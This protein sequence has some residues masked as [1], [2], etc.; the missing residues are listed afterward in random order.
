MGCRATTH[1]PKQLPVFD[2][3]MHFKG[4]TSG[5]AGPNVSCRCFASFFSMPLHRPSQS[6]CPW[7]VVGT[8]ILLPNA[9]TC[10]TPTTSA[11]GTAFNWIWRRQ[12]RVMFVHNA[13]RLCSSRTVGRRLSNQNGK[14]SISRRT[15]NWVNL[16][17]SSAR[18][19]L[20]I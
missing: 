11:G 12:A 9:L 5:A 20:T 4:S 2:K 18:L 10:L 17:C 8:P 6:S 1:G 14:P 7:K 19:Q 16:S 13:S 15:R 3:T